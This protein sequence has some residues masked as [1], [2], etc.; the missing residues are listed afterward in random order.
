LGWI[1]ESSGL[2]AE[3]SLTEHAVEESILHIELLNWPVV[4]GSNGEHRVDGGRFDNR[5]KSIIAVHIGALCETPEDPTSLQ[6][7][8]SPVRETCT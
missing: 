2:T 6:A 8:K 1:R 5:A 3:D 4:G 7:V